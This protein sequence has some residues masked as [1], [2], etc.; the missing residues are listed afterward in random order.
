MP[1]ITSLA[2]V[3]DEAENFDNVDDSDDDNADDDNHRCLKV[4]PEGKTQCAA[5]LADNRSAKHRL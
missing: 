4:S 1:T 5:T 2:C 3:V